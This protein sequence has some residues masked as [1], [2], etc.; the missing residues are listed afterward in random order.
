MCLEGWEPPTCSRIA[1]QQSGNGVPEG[2]VNSSTFYAVTAVAVITN[3]VLLGTV[4]K[5]ACR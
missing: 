3:A 1:L 2:M 5:L 4:V